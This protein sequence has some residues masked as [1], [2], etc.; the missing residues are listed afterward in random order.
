M[1]SIV[2]TAKMKIFNIDDPFHNE[3]DTTPALNCV[4]SSPLGD[5]IVEIQEC[6][7]PT[8]TMDGAEIRRLL[9]ESNPHRHA[10]VAVMRVVKVA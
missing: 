7:H 6:E 8:R 10:T 5:E 4:V 1:E 9:A 2:R 3:P